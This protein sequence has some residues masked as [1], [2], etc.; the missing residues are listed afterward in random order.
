MWQQFLTRSPV[1]HEVF[2]RT[3]HEVVGRQEKSGGHGKDP[4]V[5][6]AALL[7]G[8]SEV[9]G[10]RSTESEAGD[11]TSDVRRVVDRGHDRAKKQVVS[12]KRNEALEGGFQGTGMHG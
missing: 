2:R 8:R 5:P 6:S 9:R 4:P 10:E 11:Q 3:T 12:S 7:T 1:K